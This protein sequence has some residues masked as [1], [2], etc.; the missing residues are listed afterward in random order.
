MQGTDRSVLPGQLKMD[1]DPWNLFGIFKVLFI[2]IPYILPAQTGNNL[3][4]KPF[5]KLFS[6]VF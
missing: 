5:P 1:C 4:G 6:R 3:M 2:W